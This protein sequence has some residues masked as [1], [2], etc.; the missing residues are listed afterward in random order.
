VIDWDEYTG[1]LQ[2]I[3]SVELRAR[4]GGYLESTDFQEGAI[5]REGQILFR[6]DPAPYKATYDEA[7]GIVQQAQAK[8]DNAAYEFI[9]IDK[10]R[11]SGGGSEKEFQ[12]AKYNKAQTAAALESA[13]ASA[14]NARLNLEWTQ[15]KAPI[16]GRVSRKFVTKGN[17]ITGGTASG[18][19]LTTIESTDPIYCYIDADEGSVLKYARLAQE[20]KRVSARQAQI[21]T[22]MQL[23]NEEGFPHEGVVDFVDNRIDPNT[24]TLRG[25]GVFP[26]P[27]GWML[28][29]FFAR[30]RVPGSGRYHALLVPDAAVDTNQNLKFLRV[31]LN[32]DTVEARTVKLGSL[33]GTLRVIEDGLDPSER[34]VINGLQRAIPGTKVSPTEASIDASGMR[35]TAPGSAAT[36]ALPATR[37]LPPA[38]NATSVDLLTTPDGAAT[39]PATRP[40]T[41]SEGAK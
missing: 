26:N 29:G 39:R 27:G 14:E 28:P 8:A 15:V 18:T 30:V 16:T 10:L 35:A 2:A 13:K 37:M 12:D 21:P 38:T 36:Q 25:R 6:I 31:L 4:V 23:A 1:R 33:F 40:T 41:A 7:V 34:V 22:F 19:L 20:K 5:V 32:D 24:G 11:Q 17:L 3:D 9:R